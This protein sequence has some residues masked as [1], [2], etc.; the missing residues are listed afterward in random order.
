MTFKHAQ[1]LNDSTD[2]DSDAVDLYLESCAIGALIGCMPDFIEGT[3]AK[4]ILF[5]QQ[6]LQA[7]PRF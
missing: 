1:D 3:F 4:I 7:Q 6:Q 5:L 2:F